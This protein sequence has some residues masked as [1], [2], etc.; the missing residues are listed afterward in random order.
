VF[1]RYFFLWNAVLPKKIPFAE[2]SSSIL[3]DIGTPS[4]APEDAKSHSYLRKPCNRSARYMLGLQPLPAPSLSQRLFFSD[5]GHR[6]GGRVSQS[7]VPPFPCRILGASRGDLSFDFFP[8]GIVLFFFARHCLLLDELESIVLP[9]PLPSESLEIIFS[10]PLLRAVCR[11][12]CSAEDA[13]MGR[14]RILFHGAL[15][16]SQTSMPQ[17]IL[18][19]LPYQ[20]TF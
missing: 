2:V 12:P 18:G 17:C 20:L 9:L 3:D 10:L 13:L 19:L 7:V 11:K 14:L 15:L 8:A 5:P 4:P 16:P 1:S 6:V